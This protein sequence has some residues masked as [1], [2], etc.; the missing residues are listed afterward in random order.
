MEL[1]MGMIDEGEKPYDCAIRELSEETGYTSS[2]W[3][4]VKEDIPFSP[5]STAYYHA[6]IA[7]DAELTD[8]INL[9]ETEDVG[10]HLMS[11]KDFGQKILLEGETF[12]PAIAWHCI[13]TL[14]AKRLYS[15]SDFGL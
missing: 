4:T 2:N 11:L 8:Q 12:S 5:Y 6:Y 13:H 15:W 3:I 14:V 10:L 9:D 7:I 1:P